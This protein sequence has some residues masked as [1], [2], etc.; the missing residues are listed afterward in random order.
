MVV[1]GMGNCMKNSVRKFKTKSLP[2]TFHGGSADPPIAVI[3][4][5]HN[6]TQITENSKILDHARQGCLSAC[7]RNHKELLE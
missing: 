4:R 6:L 7:S 5:H 3:T 1:T 2:G